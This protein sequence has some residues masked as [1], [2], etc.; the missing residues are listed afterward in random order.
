[1][2]AVGFYNLVIYAEQ[3]MTLKGFV[4]LMF[5]TWYFAFF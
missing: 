4:V 5:E 3:V 2:K 1:M